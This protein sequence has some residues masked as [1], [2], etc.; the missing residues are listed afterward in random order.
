MEARKIHKFKRESIAK[1]T[2]RNPKHFRKYI[3][4][5]TSININVGELKSMDSNGK[6]VWVTEEG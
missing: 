5:K 1:L 3:K 4:S 6:E 2:K